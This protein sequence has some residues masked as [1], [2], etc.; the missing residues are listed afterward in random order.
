MACGNNV[1]LGGMEE[2]GY[3]DYKNVISDM[4]AASRLIFFTHTELSV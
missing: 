2:K 3:S 1:T 4:E